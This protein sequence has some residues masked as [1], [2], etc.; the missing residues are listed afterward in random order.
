MFRIIEHKHGVSTITQQSRKRIS[1]G[2][3]GLTELRVYD[4]LLNAYAALPSIAPEP[5][6]T[7][8]GPNRSEAC[9]VTRVRRCFKQEIELLAEECRAGV[10]G[11]ASDA[12]ARGG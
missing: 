11:D 9:D 2:P 6:H 12:T 10:G 3:A 4:E 8:R 1:V 5:A 7:C